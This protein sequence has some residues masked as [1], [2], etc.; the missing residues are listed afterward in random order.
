MPAA[1][2]SPV[3]G[4][5]VGEAAEHLL[6]VVLEQGQLALVLAGRL[7]VGRAGQLPHQRLEP[8]QGRRVLGPLLQ[9]PG[10]LVE[11]LALLVALEHVLEVLDQGGVVDRGR[12]RAGVAQPGG[13]AAVGVAGRLGLVGPALGRPH[14]PE[15]ADPGGR[16]AAAAEQARDLLEVELVEPAGL[17]EVVVPAVGEHEQVGQ[18]LAGQL[19]Q[20]GVDLAL[21][22]LAVLVEADLPVGLAGDLACHGGLLSRSDQ[23][24]GAHQVDQAVALEVALAAQGGGRLLEDPA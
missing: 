19:G 12:R 24:D 6:G 15:G 4:D 13:A 10:Q 16:A 3:L 1:P 9:Q 23:L 17:A 8:G 2:P 14:H 11:G 20:Q 5:G 18:V 7:G 22:G 21:G